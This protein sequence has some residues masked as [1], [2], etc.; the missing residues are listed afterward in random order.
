MLLLA[1]VPLF[2]AMAERLPVSRHMAEFVSAAKK[3]KKKS[4]TS[5]EMSSYQRLGPSMLCRVKSAFPFI[6]LQL[7]ARHT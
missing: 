4:K 7:N 5:N 1:K 6:S 3:K 2:R